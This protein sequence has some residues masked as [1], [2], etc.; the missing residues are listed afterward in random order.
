[1][2]AQTLVMGPLAGIIS[3]LGCV[4]PVLMRWRYP[5]P[6]VP[7]SF[8]TGHG[9]VSVSEVERFAQVLRPYSEPLQVTTSSDFQRSPGGHPLI[10]LRT[11]GGDP[12]QTHVMLAVPPVDRAMVNPRNPNP[13]VLM[14][15]PDEIVTTPSSGRCGSLFGRLFG[16]RGTE[17]TVISSAIINTQ[18]LPRMVSQAH[19]IIALGSEAPVMG[20]PGPA[21]GLYALDGTR[22]IEEP[23]ITALCSNDSY[24]FLPLLGTQERIVDGREQHYISQGHIPLTSILAIR[25]T[26]VVP[27]MAGPI[28][29][30]THQTTITGADGQPL[31]YINDNSVWGHHLVHPHSEQ[32]DYSD[33]LC[34][35]QLMHPPGHPQR[36]LFMNLFMTLD[37]HGDRR[38]PLQ[39]FIDLVSGEVLAVLAT[40]NP[41]TY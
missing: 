1:M 12:H 19:R 16:R 5:C 26:P 35:A 30:A 14:R 28:T 7:D 23:T 34:T 27:L 32:A 22:T 24:M 21:L 40:L 3:L 11:V 29:P 17:T 39:M 18:A 6:P 25:P 33:R 4:T 37:R 10:P 15:F 8:P 31:A 20:P 9:P 38:E 2:L 36:A 41:Y 13:L